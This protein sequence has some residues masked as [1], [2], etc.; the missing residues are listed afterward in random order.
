MCIRFVACGENDYIR[1]IGR[2]RSRCTSSVSTQ[3]ISSFRICECASV[4]MCFVCH[5]NA[6]CCALYMYMFNRH[7]RTYKQ[8]FFSV[9]FHLKTTKNYNVLTWVA[10]VTHTMLYVLCILQIYYK[11]YTLSAIISS[12][13]N[14]YFCQIRLFF[15]WGSFFVSFSCLAV[16]ICLSVSFWWIS[17]SFHLSSVFRPHQPNLLH[18]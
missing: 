7:I 14:E 18:I 3:P 1:V 10:L 15:V 6:C 8:H 2:G 4:S 17:R 13:T 12:L 11:Y 5:L 9:R 16:F